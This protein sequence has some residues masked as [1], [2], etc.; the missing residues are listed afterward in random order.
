MKVQ[1][2]IWIIGDEFEISS[3]RFY[4]LYSSLLNVNKRARRSLTPWWYQN[5]KTVFDDCVSSEKIYIK[6]KSRE[7]IT[8]LLN[9]EDKNLR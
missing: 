2:N 6:C 4:A 8:Q 7:Q 3:F 5:R 9:T 1:F